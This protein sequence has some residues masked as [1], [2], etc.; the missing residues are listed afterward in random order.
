MAII[1]ISN[2]VIRDFVWTIHIDRFNLSASVKPNGGEEWMAQPIRTAIKGLKFLGLS[3]YSIAGD[4]VLE[5]GLYQGISVAAW[6]IRLKWMGNL[7]V[8]FE[9]DIDR[10]RPYRL[11]WEEDNVCIIEYLQ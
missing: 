6:P 3:E 1:Y 5:P 10:T 9:K 4:F 2:E 11:L 8:L 7:N